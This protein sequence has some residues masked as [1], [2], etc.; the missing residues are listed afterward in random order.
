MYSAT[1]DVT[2]FILFRVHSTTPNLKLK[3]SLSILVL[4]CKDTIKLVEVRAINLK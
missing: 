3:I 4:S 1:D 2:I